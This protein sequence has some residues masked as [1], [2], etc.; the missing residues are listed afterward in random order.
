MTGVF[1][2]EL[3]RVGHHLPIVL[4]DDGR[5]QVCVVL[6]DVIEIHLQRRSVRCHQLADGFVVF[7]F[8]VFLESA[9]EFVYELARPAPQLAQFTR[10]LR[11]SPETA[12][13]SGRRPR[14]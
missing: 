3:C 1:L 7:E 6:F 14:L 5:G 13:G 12:S 8:A 10:T 11:G 4:F 2:N 9:M